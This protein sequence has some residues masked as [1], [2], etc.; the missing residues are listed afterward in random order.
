M[1]SNKT[2]NFKVGDR[3]V[4]RMDSFTAMMKLG[5]DYQ[6]HG[7]ILDIEYLD[8]EKKVPVYYICLMDDMT[9]KMYME[10]DEIEEEVTG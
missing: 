5:S 8:P 9:K 10:I 4:Q 2:L 7:Q 1:A 3:I 6:S